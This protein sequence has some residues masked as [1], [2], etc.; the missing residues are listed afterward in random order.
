[1]PFKKTLFLCLFIIFFSKINAQ[2]F[3]LGKV[4]IAE[5]Q[6]KEHPIDPTADAAILFNKA[7][8]VFSYDVKNG[9]SI[10]TEQVFRIKIYKKEGLKWANSKVS[11]YV[12]Y[13]HYNDDKVEFDDCVTYNI[14]KGKIVKTKLTREGNIKA[15]INKYWK[16]AGITMPNVRVGSVIE[17]KYILKS[18]NIVKF[19]VFNFQQD[20]PVNYSEYLTKIPGF[21]I[22]KAIKKGPFEIKFQSKIVRGMLSY[23]DK[24]NITR[25]KTVSFEQVNN[26]YIAENIPALKEE[27]FVDNVDNYRSSIYNELEQTRFPDEKA[28]DYSLTWEGVT[29]NIFK[30]DD[31]GKQLEESE[32]L[33]HDIKLI[34][35]DVEDKNK[36][37]VIFEFVKNK[38]NWNNEY[39]YFADK[40]VKKAYLEKTGNCAEINFI[41]IAMLK[42][43]GIN[44]NPVLISTI[45][46]GIPVY[47]NRTVFNYVVAATEIDGKQVLLDATQ[48]YTTENILP[49]NAL[50]GTGRLIRP[51]GTSEEI[52]LAPNFQS[53]VNTTVLANVDAQGQISGK[54]RIQ[55]TNYEAYSFREKNILISNETYLEKLENELAG[56]NISDYKIENRETDLTN[57]VTETFTFVSNNH[58]ERI[59]E[60]LFLNPLLFF[61]FQKNPFVMEKRQMPIYFGFPKQM[62]YNLSLGIP[63]E[64][65]VE[66]LPSSMKI[67]TEDNTA[68]FI[69][70]SEAKGNKVQISII[71]EINKSIVAAEYY[72]TIRNFFQKMIVAQNEKIVLKKI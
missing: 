70:N 33:Q 11:Y 42:L 64:Y 71:S 65:E 21:F 30:N 23:A 25:T 29:K 38:M 31:F 62:R 55:K 8:T 20:I 6:E 54:L 18:E 3:E 68:I 43:A 52:N 13:D 7:K 26:K 59:G 32:Y 56:L 34:L 45:D 41:L 60:K 53:N 58:C 50:N 51:D 67:T 63:K 72:E 19:P 14:E 9:F 49:L 35:K 66:S 27:P 48:K 10:N 22:Y 4:S 61:T 15:S 2:N 44:V 16:E 12:G 24:Y 36:Q 1:M 47:P 28:K 5:L 17:Y 40:G 39:G 37:N 69:I 57:P 46:H